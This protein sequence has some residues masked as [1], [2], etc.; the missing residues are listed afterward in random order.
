MS[1]KTT[2]G[3]REKPSSPSIVFFTR[4]NPRKIANDIK[5]DSSYCAPSSRP[6]CVCLSGDLSSIGG[7]LLRQTCTEKVSRSKARQFS[8]KFFPSCKLPPFYL[9]NSFGSVL[10]G[11]YVRFR[12]GGG[13]AGVTHPFLTEVGEKLAGNGMFSALA[14]VFSSEWTRKNKLCRFIMDGKRSCPVSVF[15]ETWKSHGWGNWSTHKEGF[16]PDPKF[17]SSP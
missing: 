3:K 16:P 6:D 8:S 12:G 14:H 11:K 13:V 9:I 5:D 4:T 2:V 17:L 1:A 15:L 7:Y 10:L